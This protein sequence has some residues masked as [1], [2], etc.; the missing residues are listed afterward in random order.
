MNRPPSPRARLVALGLLCFA[1]GLAPGVA[2]SAPV[3]PRPAVV[4]D[5]VLYGAAY[6]HEETTTAPTNH[7]ATHGEAPIS[8]SIAAS[9]RGCRS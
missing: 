8:Q 5:T 3:P 6:Y 2:T 4:P 9:C 7:T 1:W